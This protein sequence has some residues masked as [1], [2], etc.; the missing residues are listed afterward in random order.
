MKKTLFII[1]AGIFLLAVALYCVNYQKN[2]TD[3]IHTMFTE[4]SDV[5]TKSLELGAYTIKQVDDNWNWEYHIYRNNKYISSLYRCHQSGF[6]PNAELKD[7]NGHI[8]LIADELKGKGTGF[9]DNER[10]WYDLS[11]SGM[12]EVLRYTKEYISADPSA[13]YFEYYST[14]EKEITK[15]GDTFSVTIKSEKEI[16]SPESEK[17]FMSFS[18]E[19]TYKL[20]DNK[21][22]IINEFYPKVDLIYVQDSITDF[23]LKNYDSLNELAKTGDEEDK[24]WVRLLMSYCQNDIARINELA[25]ICFS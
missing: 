7:F 5:N 10:V 21:S 12:P 16:A 18:K 9:L 2:Y 25:D 3:N 15:Y 1:F 19:N 17:V 4:D 23:V 13:P 20:T 22:E 14:E 8:W 11:V 24:E 6:D